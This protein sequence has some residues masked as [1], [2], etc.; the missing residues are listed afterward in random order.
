MVSRNMMASMS[1]S[2]EKGYKNHSS[3]SGEDVV[4]VPV[5]FAGLALAELAASRLLSV[6]HLDL[7][8]PNLRSLCM[9]YRDSIA[10]LRHFASG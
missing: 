2:K 6:S 8:S 9:G 10:S 3:N 1:A 4:G 7:G 5:P